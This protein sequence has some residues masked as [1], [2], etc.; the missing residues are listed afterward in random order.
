[1]SEPSTLDSAERLPHS[2]RFAADVLRRARQHAG[3]SQRALATRAGTSQPAIAAYEQS[4]RQP[5]VATLNRL[6]RACGFVLS[7]ALLPV[8]AERKTA[9]SLVD[10]LR[11]GIEDGEEQSL[12]RIVAHWYSDLVRA[13]PGLVAYALAVD[14]GTTGDKR[15]DALVGGLGERLA[16]LRGLAVP[17][18]TAEPDRT[19]DRWWFLAPF[20][21]LHPA[22]LVGTPPEL[23]NRGV[24]VHQSSLESV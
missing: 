5:T 16:R 9:A 8:Q 23:A 15:W 24:F 19:L 21:S 18:W 22:A 1:M 20:V 13:D 3:L 17:A 2:D 4:E 12:V 7:G 14:P 11:Q 6:L 10:E